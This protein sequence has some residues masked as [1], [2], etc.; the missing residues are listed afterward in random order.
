MISFGTG[1]FS[2]S[3]LDESTFEELLD[4]VFDEHPQIKSII[5]GI[6]I[7]FIIFIIIFPLIIYICYTVR[8]IIK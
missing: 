4:S 6:T 5:Y 8:N 3:K 7:S 2:H 1:L